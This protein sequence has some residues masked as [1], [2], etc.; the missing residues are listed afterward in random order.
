MIDIIIAYWI[1]SYIYMSYL[2]TNTIDELSWVQQ[3]L[4]CWS[5]VITAPLIAPATVLTRIHDIIWPEKKE[6]KK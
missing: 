2:T 5:L 1:A 3:T 6:D 4:F